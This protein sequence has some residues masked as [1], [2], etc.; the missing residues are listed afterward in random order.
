MVLVPSPLH[1][2][3]NNPEK[4]EPS[5]S[6]VGINGLRTAVLLRDSVDEE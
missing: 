2:Q 4:C 5:F 3:A 6:F 1:L